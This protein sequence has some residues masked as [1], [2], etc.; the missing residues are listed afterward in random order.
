MLEEHSADTAL[1][2]GMRNNKC[3]FGA[4]SL[5]DSIVRNT[6]QSLLLK[7]SH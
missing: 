3:D 5:R 2:I 7:G 1:L 4:I 6:D